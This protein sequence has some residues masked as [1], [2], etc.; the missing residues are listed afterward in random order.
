MAD[1]F[2]GKTK[3]EIM[4]EIGQI[5]EDEPGENDIGFDIALDLSGKQSWQYI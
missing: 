5:S 1:L 2:K 4:I 3:R